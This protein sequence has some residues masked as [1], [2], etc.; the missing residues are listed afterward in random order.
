MKLLAGVPLVTK[1]IADHH[2][3]KSCRSERHGGGGHVP[4][5]DIAQKTWLDLKDMVSRSS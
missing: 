1:K 5:E 3:T 4:P 2:S